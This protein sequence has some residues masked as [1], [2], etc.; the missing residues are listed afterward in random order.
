MTT[1]MPEVDVDVDAM[2]EMFPYNDE[3]DGKNH[4][5]HIVRPFDNQHIQ[6]WINMQA[7]DIV[8]SARLLGW[9]ITALCGYRFI[10]MRNPEKYEA[11]KQCVDIAGHIM[12]SLGE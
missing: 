2:R 12:S 10:P 5:T 9:E 7:Q 6:G 3:D 11:C 4:K 8:D 1:V